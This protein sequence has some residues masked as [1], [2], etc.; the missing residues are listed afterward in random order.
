MTNPPIWVLHPVKTDQHGLLPSLI[1]VF[2]VYILVDKG[3]LAFF[4]RT[5]KTYQLHLL[6]YMYS[7]ICVVL[8]VH[9]YV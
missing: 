3:C 9:L 6:I 8:Y 2:A 5:L 7:F 4:M 1:R